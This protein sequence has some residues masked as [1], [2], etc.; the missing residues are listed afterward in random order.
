MA[1]IQITTI[2]VKLMTVERR[3]ISRWHGRRPGHRGR[4]HGEGGDHSCETLKVPGCTCYTWKKSFKKEKRS[5]VSVG[6]CLHADTGKRVSR[7]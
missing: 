3:G 6:R 4:R 2:Y 7:S 1:H 5:V